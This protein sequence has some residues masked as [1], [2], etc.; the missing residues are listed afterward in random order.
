MLCKRSQGY[1]AAAFQAELYAILRAFILDG[2]L[3]CLEPRTLGPTYPREW[4]LTDLIRA[5]GGQIAEADFQGPLQQA[6]KY[7][8]YPCTWSISG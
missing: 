8:E 6:G 2:W 3:C 1:H 5:E 7:S 4:Y